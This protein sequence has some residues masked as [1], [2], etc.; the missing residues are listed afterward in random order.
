METVAAL[1]VAIALM[2]TMTHLATSAQQISQMVVKA[3][4][5]GRTTLTD[6]EWATIGQGDDAAR[7]ALAAAIAKALR[8]A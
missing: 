3:Q 4:G 2:D 6:A 8:V 7:V 5:E 1:N